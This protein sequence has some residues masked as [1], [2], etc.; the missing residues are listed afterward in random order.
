WGRIGTRAI[1]ALSGRA[2]NDAWAVDA[3]SQLWHW[4][5]AVW[6]PVAGPWQPGAM[7]GKYDP[8]PPP[9]QIRAAWHAPSG[10]LYL[11][12]DEGNVIRATWAPASLPG[13]PTPAAQFQTLPSGTWLS[14]N[15]VA[16]SSDSDLWICGDH[17][18]LG[19]WNGAKMQT[20]S[21]TTTQTLQAVQLA[22]ALGVFAVGGRG[23]WLQVGA[24]GAVVD[25]SPSDLRVDLRGVLP[26]FDGGFVAVGVPV[27]VMGPYLEM[28]LLQLPAPGQSLSGPTG[29]GR[30]VW[31][32]KP[33]ID[34]TLNMLRLADDNYQTRWEMLVRGNVT[35][36]ELPDFAA[37]GVDSPL[38]SGTAYVRLWRIYNQGLD[39]DNFTFKG[40]S[41]AGWRSWAYMVRST[42]EPPWIPGGQPQPSSGSPQPGFDPPWPK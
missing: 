35:V 3:G 41:S 30:V 24:S 33:G 19:H 4:D 27:L 1:V 13:A 38:P 22:G 39:V 37:F 23:T 11:A 16:G 42:E 26:T 36:V 14:L 6:T 21:T 17:G 40:L 5:G 9:K 15:S 2:H 31:T 28:P 10:N 20:I 34:P 8:T 12:G 32:A 7:P 29:T 18:Y 25:R